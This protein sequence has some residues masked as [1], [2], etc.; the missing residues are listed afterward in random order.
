MSLEPMNTLIDRRELDFQLFDVL[1]VESL[2][3]FPRYAEHNRETFGAVLDTALSIAEDK[4]APHNRTA[5]ENEPEFD[6]ARVSVLP[7]VKEALRAFT[8]AGFLAAGDDEEY[9]G[10]QLPVCVTQ[11]AVSIF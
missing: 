3:Q 5:D 1:D 11:A 8:D 6:G 10:M 2:T 4:F 7:E 9:G